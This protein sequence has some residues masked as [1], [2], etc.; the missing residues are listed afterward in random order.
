MGCLPK[1]QVYR[2]GKTHLVKPSAEGEPFPQSFNSIQNIWASECPIPR[3]NIRTYLQP[4][5]FPAS[6]AKHQPASTASHLT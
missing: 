1:W 5:I 4:L 3:L 2:L 6:K